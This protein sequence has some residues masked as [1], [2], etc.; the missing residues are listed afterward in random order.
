MTV[1]SPLALLQAAPP[2]DLLA[3][4]APILR[5]MLDAV[6]HGNWWIVVG[7]I[8]S[9]LAVAARR[10]GPRLWPPLGN[11]WIL[12]AALFVLGQL[13]G[14]VHALAAGVPWGAAVFAAGVRVGAAAAV[15]AGLLELLLA[16]MAR[17][18][19]PAASRPTCADCPHE[20]PLHVGE[21][22]RCLAPGCRCRAWRPSPAA[23]GA[24]GG[25]R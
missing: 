3:E 22:K 25:G 15:Q 8:C 5:E 6:V 19:P 23:V 14:M 24:A 12:L 1:L 17:R 2:P 13:G 18:L 20:A 11:P 10:V 16:A 7:T 21:G 9:A 4:L